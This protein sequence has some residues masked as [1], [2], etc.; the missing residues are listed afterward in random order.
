[1]TST[2]T[3]YSRW[4]RRPLSYLPVHRQGQLI[5]YLWA[6]TDHHAAGFERQLATAGDD[7]DCLLAWERRLDN[8]AGRGLAPIAALEEWI[9]VTEDAVAGVVPPGIR[10]GSAP[11][12]AELWAR[13]NPDGPPLDEGPLVQDGTYPDGTPADRSDGWGPLR[14][15]PLQTYADDTDAPVRYLPVRMNGTVVGYIWAA[16]TGEAGGYLPRTQAGRA[17]E[18]AAGLWQL[19]FSDAYLAG[20]PATVA[21]NRCRAFP[22]DRL[23]GVIG[24]DAIE[25]EVSGLTEVKRLAEETTTGGTR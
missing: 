19:R 3:A 18:I 13:L 1:M 14:S 5:G 12:L 9:G 16:I 15:V 10:L 6:S 22:A 24:A 20:Q 2:P 25:R 17:G 11:S 21:L 7:L 4:T 8:A 23:S